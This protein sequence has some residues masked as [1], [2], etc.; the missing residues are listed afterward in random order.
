MCRRLLNA[1]KQYADKGFKMHVKPETAVP[2][3]QTVQDPVK[4]PQPRL[5]EGCGHEIDQGDNGP[6][7][8]NCYKDG[9]GAPSAC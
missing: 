4:L 5:P 3:D 2:T 1:Q 9:R 7:A 8:T 6:N